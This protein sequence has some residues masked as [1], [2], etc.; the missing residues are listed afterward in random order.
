M[1]NP[2]SVGE[3]VQLLQALILFSV[4]QGAIPSSD[5]AK[6]IGMLL[7]IGMEQLDR[8]VT[9]P[10]VVQVVSGVPDDEELGVEAD[11]VEVEIK[12]PL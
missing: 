5:V 10:G 12:I 6:V 2:S 8:L 4:G 3:R 1:V 7:Q 9:V 11:G